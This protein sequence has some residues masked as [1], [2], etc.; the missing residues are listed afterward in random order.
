MVMPSMTM[1]SQRSPRPRAP[2]SSRRTEPTCSNERFGGGPRRLYTPHVRAQG[3]AP[4]SKVAPDATS[5]PGSSR[6]F[7]RIETGVPSQ[8]ISSPLGAWQA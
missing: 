1:P 6:R 4:E 8:Y 3:L 7:N 5:A 2:P